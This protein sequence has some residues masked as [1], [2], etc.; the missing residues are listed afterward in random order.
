MG[1]VAR[2]LV[3]PLLDRIM[4]SDLL[5]DERRKCAGGARG[6]VLEVGIGSGLNFPYYGTAVSEVVGVDPSAGLQ[7]RAQ[8][9]AADLGFPVRHVEASAEAMPLDDASFDTALTTWSLCSIPDPI[10]ALH[11]I[12][13]ALKPGGRLLF[14]EHG[15]SPDRGVARWQNR[16]N[17]AWRCL[18]AGCN[19]NR[20]MDDL[21][22]AA[23]FA[24]DGLETGY[25]EGPRVLGYLYRGAAQP[26]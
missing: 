4:Q 19:M 13:R 5:I 25:I 2:Y 6:R 20:R 22:E 8:A 17:G 26:R 21:I 9:R 23:G 15:L 12:R 10:A 7:K 18:S 14:V 24:I 11:E 3:P 16:L 1:L